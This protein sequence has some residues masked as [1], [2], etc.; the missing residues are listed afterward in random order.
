MLTIALLKEKLH[1]AATILKN[2]SGSDVF[3]SLSDL[4]NLLNDLD[5]QLQTFV[6]ELYFLA[7]A[8]EE[9]ERGRITHNDIDKVV[10]EM[11]AVILPEMEVPAE[12]LSA[13][14]SMRLLVRGEEYMRVARSW[15][16]FALEHPRLSA[17]ELRARLEALVDGLLFNTF[18]QDQADIKV[19]TL[20]DP[21]E[22]WATAAGF[23]D[24]LYQSGDQE[25]YS[26]NQGL[27][28]PKPVVTADRFFLQ[29]IAIQTEENRPRA[30][31]A[32]DLMH[33]NL[34]SLV[35]LEYTSNYF[36]SSSYFVVGQAREGQL[37]FL[38]QHYFWS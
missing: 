28:N 13:G 21:P 37:V 29:F 36:E 25:L 30:Q 6:N 26:I 5:G 22:N 14:E 33:Q 17:E 7:R 11:E 34:S 4:E 2:A 18:Y 23:S 16:D 35:L 19:F 31:E 3:I 1:E 12:P 15:K 9:S 27:E 32:V 38:Y 10:R 20:S 8:L 24:A